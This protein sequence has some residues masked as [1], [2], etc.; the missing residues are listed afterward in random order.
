MNGVSCFY[1]AATLAVCIVGL[2]A[3]W[4]EQKQEVTL[5]QQT[6]GF[7]SVLLT[8]NMMYVNSLESKLLSHLMS[9]NYST[10]SSALDATQLLHQTRFM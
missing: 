10:D 9:F 8:Q 7:A 2:W 1:S 6:L 5:M 4:T 3:G